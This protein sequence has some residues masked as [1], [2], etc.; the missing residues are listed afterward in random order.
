[1]TILRTIPAH[2][3]KCDTDVD[4]TIDLY[5]V[6]YNGITACLRCPSCNT[7]VP[8]YSFDTFLKT[9]NVVIGV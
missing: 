1:M 8:H 7:I 2:C 9:G 6:E 3:P 5:Y 4:F